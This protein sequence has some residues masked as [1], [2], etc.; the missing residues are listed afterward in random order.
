MRMRALTHWGGLS[1]TDDEFK[2]MGLDHFLRKAHEVLARVEG[3]KES[4]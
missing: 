3:R 1:K 2:D 4:Q